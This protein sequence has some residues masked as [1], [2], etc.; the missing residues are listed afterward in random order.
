VGELPA[1]WTSRQPNSSRQLASCKP[2]ASLVWRPCVRTMGGVGAVVTGLLMM[3]VLTVG[4]HCCPHFLT[5]TAKLTPYHSCI[6]CDTGTGSPDAGYSCQACPAGFQTDAAPGPPL[7][8]C[9]NPAACN[10]PCANGGKCVGV[11]NCDCS[12]TGFEGAT[13]SVRGAGEGGG[14]GLSW[15]R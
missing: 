2:A 7:P 11:N 8:K 3:R 15:P 14:G 1:S 13:C 10:P 6:A 9:V 12:G 4:G 5:L